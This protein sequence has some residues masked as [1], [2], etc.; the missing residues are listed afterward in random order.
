MIKRGYFDRA[1]GYVMKSSYLAELKIHQRNS[2]K[3][4]AEIQLKRLRRIIR[5]AYEHVPYYRDLFDIEK[6]KPESIKK[7]EDLQ[8]IP[9]TTKKDI[10]ANY[11][12]IFS[13]NIERYDILTTTGSTGIPLRICND[14]KSQFY[15]DA[16]LLY[17]FSEAGLKLRD[18]FVEISAITK[19]PNYLDHKF[20]IFRRDEI[21]LYN[22]MEK[23]IEMLQKYKPDAIYTF[24]SVLRT[25]SHFLDNEVSL[26]PR[27]IFTHG[28]TLTESCREIINSAFGT[29]IMNTYGSTEFNRL[30]FECDEHSGLHM[31]TDCSVIDF[32][33]DGQNVDYGCE[34]EII[35]TGLYNY[36][37]PLIRYNLGDIGI[38][39]DEE[40]PC[41]RNWPLIKSI[42]GRSDDYLILPSGKVISPRNINVIEGIPGIIQYRTIQERKD[43]F[44]VLIIPDKDFSSETEKKIKEKINLGCLGENI[45]IEIRLVDEIPRERTGKLK[46]IISQI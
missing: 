28:E 37:M 6:I 40:C 44:V 3:E 31:I 35:V 27:L 9:I 34:G 15:T 20:R 4:L 22:S 41:G 10:Q 30:A 16:L 19:Q 26:M 12:K 11:G 5:H 39:T 25:M 2:K 13:N 38:P 36:K 17:A 32:V 43:R 45:N 24:P 42:E 18:R 8:R 7:L 21:S 29:E 23:I 14:R 1:I 46:T 33:K